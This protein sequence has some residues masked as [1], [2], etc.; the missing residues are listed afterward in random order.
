M[1]CVVYALIVDNFLRS[2]SELGILLIQS[3]FYFL[4]TAI[5]ILA[6]LQKKESLQTIGITKINLIKSCILGILLG[7]IFFV[8]YRSLLKTNNIIYII[9]IAS[10]ISFIKYIIV[11]FS[12]EIIFRGYF[13]TRL[14]AWLGTTKGCLITAII[15]SFY[16]LPVN[17]IFKGMDMQSAFLSCVNLI[18][19]SLVLG[20][21]MIKTKNIITVSIL[22]TFIDWSQSLHIA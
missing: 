9:S 7:I 14:I 3:S 18:P 13:Q 21:I 6:V 2:I 5:V 16:H 1:I 11:G 20:Y 19:L 15:F 10:L 17:L 4:L 22:H 12:E 8:V